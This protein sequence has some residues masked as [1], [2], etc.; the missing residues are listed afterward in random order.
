MY[1]RP[2]D[3]IHARELEGCIADEDLFFQRAFKNLAP[4]GWFEIKAS[5]SYFASDDDSRQRAHNTVL[6]E[7]K[8][9]E[10]FS[11]FGKSLRSM[12]SW[13]DKLIKAGFV[14]VQQDV[15]KV[16]AII[17]AHCKWKAE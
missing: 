17:R 2:F 6:W 1:Q 7:K 10:G 3:Y 9:A 5:S 15:R 13:K 12:V 14:D 4:G 8:L 16:C 11:K